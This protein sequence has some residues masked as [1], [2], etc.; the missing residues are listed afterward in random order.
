MYPP[1][2]QMV[3]IVARGPVEPPVREFAAELGRLFTRELK[4]I[5]TP[6]RL[7]GPAP[8]PFAKLRGMHRYHLQ[9]QALD[10]AK[11]RTM[12]RE[13]LASV[14]KPDEIQWTADVDPLD[15]L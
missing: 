4:Q 6:S 7:L 5:D 2:A 15:M 13:T 14:P 9:L 1:F 8:A 11:L 3:R 10:G 12:V